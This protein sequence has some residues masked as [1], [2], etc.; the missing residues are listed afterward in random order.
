MV[1]EF[2][3]SSLCGEFKELLRDPDGDRKKSA[4][5]ANRDSELSLRFDSFDLLLSRFLLLTRLAVSARVD[6]TFCTKFVECRY[7]HSGGFWHLGDAI[8]E[9]VIPVTARP[10]T[11]L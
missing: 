6:A 7:S 2:F 4:K 1:T 11:L 3:L 9:T 10:M 5:D 8:F